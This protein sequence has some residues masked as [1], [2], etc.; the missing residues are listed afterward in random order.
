MFF[1]ALMAQATTGPTLQLESGGGA[2]SGAPVEDFMYFIALISPAPVFLG[3]SPGSTLKA[4]LISATRKTSRASF[5]TTCEFQFG[6]NGTQESIFDLGPEIRRREEQIKAGMPLTRQ[7]ESIVVN[8]A[9]AVT[10]EARGTIS[11]EV[12]VVNEVRAKF[13]SAGTSFVSITLCDVRW[14]GSGF[15]PTNEI[16]A[17]VNTLTFHREPGIPKMEITVGS[18]KDKEAGDGLWQSLKGSIKGAAVNLFI[19]PLVVEKEGNLAMLDFGHAL[20]SGAPTFTF[21]AAKKL[22]TSPAPRISMM[23][24]SGK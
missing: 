1:A 19:P 23:Q 20:A 9:G 2:A 18:L 15:T 17:K 7:L 6:G 16:V 11:N 3:A 10:I 21:P 5:V 12:E 4:R 22:L 8:G 13:N 14:T 24:A